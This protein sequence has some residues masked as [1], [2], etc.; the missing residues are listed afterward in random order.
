MDETASD[1]PRASSA[2]RRALF[3]GVP[4]G[5]LFAC[6][7]VAVA[8]WNG[9]FDHVL[10]YSELGG[11]WFI[12]GFAATPI[13]YVEFVAARRPA[14]TR[15]DRLAAV[16]TGVVAWVCLLAVFFEVVY[17][18]GV[19]EVGL[20]QGVGAAQARGL[21][22]VTRVV[23]ALLDEGP[24]AILYFVL[25]AVPFVPAALGRLRGRSLGR[26]VALGAAT[27]WAFSTPLVAVVDLLHGSLSRSGMIAIVAGITGVGAL[28]PL[29]YR[30]ADA[31]DQRVSR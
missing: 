8:F 5:T 27:S 29:F 26:Q 31:L 2:L 18:A 14:S 1:P 24:R 6:F 19:L 12:V 22:D 23:S 20:R 9:K 17:L 3:R 11:I 13:A 28:L 21:R 16:A 25:P 10:E 4:L 30:L 15:R 7:T